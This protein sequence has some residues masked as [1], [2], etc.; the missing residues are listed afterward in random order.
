VGF[1]QM[2]F[3]AFPKTLFCRELQQRNALLRAKEA[4]QLEALE[5][6]EALLQQVA[7]VHDN[8]TIN[9]EHAAR[10]VSAAMLDMQALS[11]KQELRPTQANTQGSTASA[12]PALGSSLHTSHRSS[13]TAGELMAASA[14]AH[15]SGSG[16]SSSAAAGS[17]SSSGT[18]GSSSSFSS[19]SLSVDSNTRMAAVMAIVDVADIPE[20]KQLTVQEIAG[21]LLGRLGGCDTA[22]TWGMLCVLAAAAA[23]AAAAA[24]APAAAAGSCYRVASIRT[25]PPLLSESCRQHGISLSC[26]LAISH[27]MWHTPPLSICFANMPHL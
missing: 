7:A 21:A 3:M 20:L 19:G 25:G 1:Q 26:A 22:H 6:W 16:N 9:E 27:C 12:P 13:A 8:A 10:L 15:I 17:S 23:A 11:L 2:L 14:P 5:G 18:S 4:M 24:V